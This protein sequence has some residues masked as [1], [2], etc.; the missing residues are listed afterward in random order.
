M[1]WPRRAVAGA[2]GRKSAGLES[3]VVPA[4]RDRWLTTIASNYTP[5][6]ISSTLRSVLYGNNQAQWALFDVMEDTWPRLAKNLGELKRS[7]VSLQWTI[8][9]WARQKSK[10]SQEAFRRAALLETAIWSMRPAAPAGENDFPSTVYDILDAWGKGVSVLEIDWELRA[11]GHGSGRSIMPRATRWIPPRYYGYPLDAANLQL[12][13]SEILAGNPA[14]ATKAASYVPFNPDK[15]IVA[16][17]RAKTGHP[18]GTALLRPLAFWWCASNFA[19]DW[20]M[21]FAQ[22]FGQPI[23]WANY[24]PNV[25]GLLDEISD[26]LENMGSAAWGAF[27]AGTVLELKEAAKAA[28][29]N[30][31]VVLLNLADK[32][33]DILILG[34]TLTTDAGDRGTQALGTVHQ[35]VRGDYISAAADWAATILNQ[36]FIP[37]FCRLNFG[38]TAEMPW[39]NPAL[40]QAKDAE[41]LAR[42]DRIIL[43]AGVPVPRQWLYERHGIPVPKP[44]E[45]VVGN[46]YGG[47]A[48]G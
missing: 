11:A 12:K 41:A 14:A 4:A 46:F 10:P 9:P 25:P 22:V 40:K 21:N 3:I 42:R 39:F 37:A 45:R 34:Q 5:D 6:T 33:C 1:G 13:S 19:S 8:Q 47:L 27:P 43:Q 30:P 26:M 15:F 28:K 31:Q 18:A 2:S 32:I 16:I 24:D 36:Q 29:D 20:L 23:R 38:D 7:V 17:A 48:R 35:Q 44:G